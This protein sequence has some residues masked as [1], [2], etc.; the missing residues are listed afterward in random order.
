M[1]VAGTLVL[2]QLKHGFG[3]GETDAKNGRTV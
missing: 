1:E 2:K 3:F